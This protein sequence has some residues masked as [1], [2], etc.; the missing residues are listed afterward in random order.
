MHLLLQ[1][2]VGLKWSTEACKWLEYFIYLICM[3]DDDYVSW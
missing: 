1:K 2:F 3:M